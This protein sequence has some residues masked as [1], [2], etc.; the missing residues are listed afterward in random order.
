VHN[1]T[2][3]AG[4]TV[5]I[6]FYVIILWGNLATVAFSSLHIGGKHFCITGFSRYSIV[7]DY[8]SDK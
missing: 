2:F 6:S 1:N 5:N 7:L 4:I 3:Q 8:F